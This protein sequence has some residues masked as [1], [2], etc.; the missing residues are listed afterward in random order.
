MFQN[1]SQIV[2]SKLNGEKRKAKSGRRWN[3]SKKLS[4]LLR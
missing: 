4:T 1:I 3:D 2:K